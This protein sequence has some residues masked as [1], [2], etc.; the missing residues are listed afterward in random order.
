M[1]ARRHQLAA[2]AA[3]AMFACNEAWPAQ[4]KYYTLPRGAHPHDVAPAPDGMV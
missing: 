1:S 2:L 3:L 4:V